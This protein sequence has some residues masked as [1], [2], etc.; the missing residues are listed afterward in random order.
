MVLDR[1]GISSNPFRGYLLLLYYLEMSKVG[2][3]YSL[4]L[5]IEYGSCVH[6]YTGGACSFGYGRT[7]Y[8]RAGA[9]LC[10]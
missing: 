4:Q 8:S 7:W 3:W 5:L 2:A 1:F 6:P 9:A 10:R